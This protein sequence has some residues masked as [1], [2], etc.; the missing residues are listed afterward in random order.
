M[1]TNKYTQ[2]YTHSPHTHTLTTHTHTHT[3][4]QTYKDIPTYKQ[5]QANIT[6]ESLTEQKTLDRDQVTGFIKETEKSVWYGIGL[7]KSS[8]TILYHTTIHQPR[9]NIYRY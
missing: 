7:E 3:H 9:V 1:K 6:S 8:Q 4:S 2:T 5:A